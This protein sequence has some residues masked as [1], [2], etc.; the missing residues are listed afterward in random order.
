MSI[1]KSVQSDLR[2]FGQVA[3]ILGVLYFVVGSAFDYWRMSGCITEVRATSV[4]SGLNFEVSE[5]DCWHNPETSVFVSKS[6]Q[7]QKTLLFAYA[8]RSV[9]TITPVDERTV[10]IGLGDIDHIFC[11]SVSWEGLAIEYGIGAVRS[12]GSH[13]EPRQC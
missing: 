12:P 3:A 13:L 7:N 2:F 8:S 1:P 6:G 5:T 10:R 4:V 11:R 9:P